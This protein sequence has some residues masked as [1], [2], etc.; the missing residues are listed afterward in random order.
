MTDPFTAGKRALED[1]DRIK[2]LADDARQRLLKF[3]GHGWRLWN[4]ERLLDELLDIM[5]WPD[6][7][8]A[9]EFIDWEDSKAK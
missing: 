4:R 7:C 5:S 1:G 9:L 6:A 2:M 3:V 8:Q